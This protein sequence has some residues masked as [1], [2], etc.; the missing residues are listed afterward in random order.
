MSG[1]R[2]SARPNPKRRR[3]TTRRLLFRVGASVLIY[4]GSFALFLIFGI[5]IVRHHGQRD[6]A[7]FRDGFDCFGKIA[8][9]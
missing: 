8:S 5:V 3:F 6:T 1:E 4:V 9:F 7:F 2:E